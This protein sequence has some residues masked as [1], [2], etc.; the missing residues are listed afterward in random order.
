[1]TDCALPPRS[2]GRAG[3]AQG[4][5]RLQIATAYFYRFDYVRAAE[6][7]AATGQ[8]AASPW[9]RLARYLVARAGSE[10]WHRV[11]SRDVMVPEIH[12]VTR[13]NRLI[14]H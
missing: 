11:G 13:R 7:Y 6:L 3:L 1:M 2:A 12:K 10:A 14:P 8:D 5:S 4:R 9:H